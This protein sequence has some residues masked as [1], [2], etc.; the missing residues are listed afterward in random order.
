MLSEAK[1]L[2]FFAR[3]HS[4]RSKLR[5]MNPQRFN[6]MQRLSAAI[7]TILHNRVSSTGG[8]DMPAA[9]A[10]VHR[11]GARY[12]H[13]TRSHGGSCAWRLVRTAVRRGWAGVCPGQRS[14]TI[15]DKATAR[16]GLQLVEPEPD[17]GK[18]ANGNS[19]H[20]E[21]S[22]TAMRGIPTG[23]WMRVRSP[24]PRARSRA[25]IRSAAFT[26]DAGTGKRE[27]RGAKP[28]PREA[29]SPRSR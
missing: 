14:L 25:F 23:G 7:L 11:G 20:P 26:D 3:M 4:A 16:H 6:G 12:P 15:C 19:H 9:C 28:T 10:R 24:W 5:G 2:R 1:H 29:D 8:E 18:I 17:R 22:S 13:Q 27:T 21:D